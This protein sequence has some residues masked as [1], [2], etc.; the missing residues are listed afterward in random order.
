MSISCFN[1]AL[2]ANRLLKQEMDSASFHTKACGFVCLANAFTLQA[3][4]SG[5]TTIKDTCVIRGSTSKASVGRK[6]SRCI[7]S[8]KKSCELFT[9]P[10]EL[11]ARPQKSFWRSDTKESLNVVKTS[12]EVVRPGNQE[13]EKCVFM[14]SNFTYNPQFT[15]KGETMKILKRH[16]IRST[17]ARERTLS[18]VSKKW[19][20]FFSMTMPFSSLP[21]QPLHILTKSLQGLRICCWM[22]FAFVAGCE[23]HWKHT[24]EV[25]QLRQLWTHMRRGEVTRQWNFGQSQSIFNQGR[26]RWS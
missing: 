8:T 1:V 6:R 23:N 11:T 24:R 9:L 12:R 22:C 3:R 10:K 25:Q 15:Y 17:D 21:L 18:V 20:L 5:A 26:L 14:E 16:S 2:E 13:S 7:S 4:C 19:K